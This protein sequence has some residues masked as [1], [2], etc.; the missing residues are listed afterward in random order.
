MT[1]EDLVLLLIAGVGAVIFGIWPGGKFYPGMT[2]NARKRE[3]PRWFG[4]TWFIVGG[5]AAVAYSLYHLL[6]K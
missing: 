1:N 2:R 4:M 5:C 6:K 3:L